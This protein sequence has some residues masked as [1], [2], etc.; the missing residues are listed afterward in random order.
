MLGTTIIAA[1]L[2]TGDT[3]SHTIRSSAVARARPRRRGRRGARRRRAAR[4]A[5]APARAGIRYFPQ[6]RTPIASRARCAARG[7]VDGVAPAIVE[8]V[9]VQDVTTRQNEP[10]VTLFAE[11][12]GAAARRSAPMQQRTA[13]RLARRPARRRGLPQRARPPTSSAPAPAT[14]CACSPGTPTALAARPRRRA[15]PTAAGT[16]R[17]GRC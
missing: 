8:P 10:R 7:L 12:P 3:M 13:T 2:A 15:L 6:A 11:R 4:A 17:R 14:R 5:R 9:A 1:A 16:D